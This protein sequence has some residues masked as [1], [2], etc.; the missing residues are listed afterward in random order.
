MNLED[1]AVENIYAITQMESTERNKACIYDI[2]E[3]S[4]KNTLFLSVL[5]IIVPNCPPSLEMTFWDFH[6][7]ESI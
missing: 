4:T 1:R 3:I 6:I 2:Q 5:F 7:I